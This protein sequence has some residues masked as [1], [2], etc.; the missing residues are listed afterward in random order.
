MYWKLKPWIPYGRGSKNH[1]FARIRFFTVSAPILESFCSP[2]R[3]KDPVLAHFWGPGWRIWDPCGEYFLRVFF[4]VLSWTPFSRERTSKGV[5][6]E[7][8]SMFHLPPLTLS[9]PAPQKTGKAELSG[10]YIYIYMYIYIYIYLYA[11]N[12]RKALEHSLVSFHI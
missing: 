5:G 7:A 6:G 3:T 12:N 2:K 11:S 9:P 8:L 4:E 1:T 10:I